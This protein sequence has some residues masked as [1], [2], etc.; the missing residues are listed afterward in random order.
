MTF[1]LPD[2]NIWELLEELCLD[3]DPRWALIL[4]IPCLF[5]FFTFQRKRVSV[6]QLSSPNREETGEEKK[7]FR[8]FADE[9]DEG[10]GRVQ[11]RD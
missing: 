2:P 11:G 5:T 4:F 3:P 7:G 6:L 1:S 8:G 9:E 10:R